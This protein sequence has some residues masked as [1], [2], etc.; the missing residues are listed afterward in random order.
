MLGSSYNQWALKPIPEQARDQFQPKCAVLLSN[1]VVLKLNEDV[2]SIS[3]TY[4]VIADS[5]LPFWATISIS[6]A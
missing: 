6:E 4:L 5:K 2:K 3:N 1:I